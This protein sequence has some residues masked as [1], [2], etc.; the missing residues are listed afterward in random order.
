MRTAVVILVGGQAL[1]AAAYATLWLAREPYLYAFG[2][3]GGTPVGISL[4]MGG[5]VLAAR[6]HP[7]PAVRWT[8]VGAGLGGALVHTLAWLALTGIRWG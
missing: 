3:M 5:F 1:L 4:A 6:R 7:Q 8:L 2:V